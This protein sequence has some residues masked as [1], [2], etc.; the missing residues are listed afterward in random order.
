MRSLAEEFGA[1]ERHAC[2][3]M[4]IA[5]T[6]HRYRSRRDDSQ[7]REQLLR[8]ARETPRFGH[9]RIHILLQ[10]EGATVNHKRV[11]RPYRELGLR[12]KRNRRSLDRV[13]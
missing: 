9:R 1:S 6:T 4:E 13:R 10:R 2:P 3:L 11:Q 7:L 5:R 8:L 12:L